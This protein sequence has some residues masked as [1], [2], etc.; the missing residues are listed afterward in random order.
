M[1]VSFLVDASFG[2]MPK[3]LNS[4]MEYFF[5]ESQ[6][7]PHNAINDAQ[8]L[9]RLCEHYAEKLGYES[10]HDYLNDQGSENYHFKRQYDN[11]HWIRDIGNY[12]L[13]IEERRSKDAA[14]RSAILKMRAP[15]R[16]ALIEMI[17]SDLTDFFYSE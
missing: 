17:G 1:K 12:S 14:L 2:G 6:P 3:D 4:C 9:K 15:E 5:G 7:T 16:A 13:T 10:F 8:C 11:E